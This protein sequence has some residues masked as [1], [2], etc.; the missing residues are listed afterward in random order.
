[1]KKTYTWYYDTEYAWLK[2][3]L[4]V[5]VKLGIHKNISPCS[6][7]KLG[8]M[9]LDKDS[10]AKIFINAMKKLGFKLEFIKKDCGDFA[11]LRNYKRWE[12]EPYIPLK[13]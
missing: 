5:L 12:C 8:V 1:M 11:S 9:Y 7:H 3:D 4:D 10:D 6:Y 2:V 13:D